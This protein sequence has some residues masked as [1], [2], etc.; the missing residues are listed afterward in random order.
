MARSSE[1]PI[2]TATQACRVPIFAPTRK[3]T[4]AV[5]LRVATQWGQAV[6]TGRLGQQHRDVLD[7]LLGTEG[8]WRN[9]EHGGIEMHFDSADLRKKLGWARWDYRHILNVLEDLRL[10]RVVMPDQHEVTGIITRVAESDQQ[11]PARRRHAGKTAAWADRKPDDPRG[12]DDEAVPRGGMMWTATIS[13]AWMRLRREMTTQYPERVFRMK[14]GVSQAA[15][16][17]MLSHQAGARYHIETV[18]EAVNAPTGHWARAKKEIEFDAQTMADCGV[19]LTSAGMLVRVPVDAR[20]PQHTG[21]EPQHTGSE[22]Q[23]T[24]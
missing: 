16:R 20:E 17:F 14:Y 3:P 18:L 12:H 6:I 4:E 2:K 21:Q 24:G 7:A 19:T 8:L 15:T 1:K 11:P 23:H 22:P 9:A 10:A 13:G 5:R